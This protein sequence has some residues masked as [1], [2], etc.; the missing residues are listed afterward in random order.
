MK[1]AWIT[2]AALTLIALPAM[3]QIRG[4]P[5]SVTSMAPGRSSNPGPP[6]SV[7]SLG[8]HG[9]PTNCSAGGISPLISSALGC[10]PIQFTTGYYSPDPRDRG[11]VNQHPRRHNQGSSYYPV[12]VPYA[13]PVAV[14]VEPEEEQEAEPDPP[15]PTIFEHRATSE[16]MPAD[17]SRYGTHY[18]D[19]RESQKPEPVPEVSDNRVMP[20][21]TPAQEQFPVL[22]IYRDGHEQEVRNYAIV[23]QTLYDLGAFVA[24]RVPLAD[25]NLPATIKANDDRGVEFALPASVKLD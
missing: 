18:L 2:I 23:G 17:N 20:S 14:A 9:Y 24:H 3:G 16:R 15:A 21:T 7:T 25:L 4:M 19:A 8:P 11:R 22:L 5:A 1:R 12:Y 6:A 10:T 13:Y